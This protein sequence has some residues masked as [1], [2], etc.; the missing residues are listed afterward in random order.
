M[1]GCCLLIFVVRA[2]TSNS[3]L[4]WQYIFHLQT[5]SIYKF[6]F[7]QNHNLFILKLLIKIVL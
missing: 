7:N 4:G 1:L 2:F 5:L 6:G 3:L